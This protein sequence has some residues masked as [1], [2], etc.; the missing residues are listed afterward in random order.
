MGQIL[1]L[2]FDQEI[3]LQEL[4]QNLIRAIKYYC[5]GK[6]T[7]FAYFHIILK[8]FSSLKCKGGGNLKK[9]SFDLKQTFSN[10]FK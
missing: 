3:T 7:K 8:K 5:L 1:I 10:T 9:P 6:D 4:M 2:S